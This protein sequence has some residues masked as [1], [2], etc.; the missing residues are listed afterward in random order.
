MATAPSVQGVEILGPV[1]D[2]FLQILTPEA[3]TF[4]ATLH[5]AFNGR[6]RELLENRKKIQAEI[7][8]G[9]MP[10]FLPETADV[11]A[12]DWKVDPTPADF[13]DRRVEITGPVDRKMVI[14]AL[15]SGAN[16]FMADFEDSNSPTWS[17]KRV[18]ARAAY[19]TRWRS[20]ALRAS[21]VG[22]ST[23]RSSRTSSRT[24]PVTG[25]T[26]VR[27]SVGAVPP[28][29]ATGP[30]PAAM[31]WRGPPSMPAGRWKPCQ[32]VVVASVR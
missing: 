4:Y 13:Q 24:S 12:G 20:P 7:D 25:V 19:A 11:R 9:K 28:G 10:G 21:M 26:T 2:E 14:N 16:V 6:R 17:S 15:N 8:G 30:G 1:T 18:E 29:S 32:C 5:R 27:H 3:L 31:G 23:A 22:N